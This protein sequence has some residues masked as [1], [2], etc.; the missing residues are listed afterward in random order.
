[1]RRRKINVPSLSYLSLSFSDSE[2]SAEEIEQNDEEE[3]EE[4]NE[5]N[6]PDEAFVDQQDQYAHNSA[7]DQELHEDDTNKSSV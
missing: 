6:E 7:S 2:N 4:E 3:Q 1:M 5:Q